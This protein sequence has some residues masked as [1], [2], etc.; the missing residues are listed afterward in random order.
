MYGDE[1]IKAFAKN[2]GLELELDDSG[3]CTFASDDFTITFTDL[4]ELES[5]ALTADIGLPP[6]EKLEKLYKFMLEA[7][8]LFNATSG[9]TLSINADSG[10]V[11]LCSIFAYRGADADVFAHAVERFVNTCESW[12]KIVAQ[13]RYGVETSQNEPEVNSQQ[14][15]FMVRV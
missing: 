9:A 7:N 2:L 1:L 14:E 11:A 10:H 15:E 4:R 8:Y 5:I 3:S 12:S 6:P 13:Y